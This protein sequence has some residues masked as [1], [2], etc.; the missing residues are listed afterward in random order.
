MRRRPSA[1]SATASCRRAIRW[2]SS[3]PMSAIRRCWWAEGMLDRLAR[4]GSLPEA[5]T[6]EV[7][8]LRLGRHWLV[9]L[10]GETMLEIGLSIER[11]LVE[12]GLAKPERGDLTLTIGYANDY[13]GYLCT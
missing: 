9:A 3:S 1:R 5:E 4:E 12:L 8:V 13:V 11:G 10:P 6:S 2:R 7:Q